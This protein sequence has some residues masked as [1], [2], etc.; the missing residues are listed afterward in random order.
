MKLNERVKDGVDKS[1][2]KIMKIFDWGT[3]QNK[4]IFFLGSGLPVSFEFLNFLLYILSQI[5]LSAVP[6]LG[7]PSISL[8]IDRKRT[9]FFKK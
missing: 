3:L 4:L 8:L 1:G 5:L 7:F 6:K 9:R 2:G